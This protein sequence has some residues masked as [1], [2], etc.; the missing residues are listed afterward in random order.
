MQTPRQAHPWPA[1]SVNMQTDLNWH[2]AG[3]GTRGAQMLA[4]AAAKEDSARKRA[5]YTSP[6]TC[7]SVCVTGAHLIVLTSS[8]QNCLGVAVLH[9]TSLPAQMISGLQP[10]SKGRRHWTS[11]R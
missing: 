1:M 4:A 5:K 3:K 7:E 6:I 8:R 9:R 10:Q 2:T 11:C